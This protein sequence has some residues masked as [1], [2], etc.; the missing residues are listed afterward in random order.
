VTIETVYGEARPTYFVMREGGRAPRHR[1]GSRYK[2]EQEAERLTLKHPGA[3]FHVVK[4]KKTLTNTSL[5]ASATD[6]QWELVGKLNEGDRCRINET[7]HEYAG[8]SGLIAKI[9]LTGDAPTVWVRLD[10]EEEKRRFSPSSIIPSAEPSD[11]SAAPVRHEKI[12]TALDR[13]YRPV[14]CDDAASICHVG[15]EQRSPPH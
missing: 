6:R 14:R 11:I 5:P 1:H 15:E 4:L 10:G 7:H 3:T 9:E 2:A 12:E 13:L 8:A